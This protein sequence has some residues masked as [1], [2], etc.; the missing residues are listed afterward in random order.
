MFLYI[1]KK[2]KIANKKKTKRAQKM[3]RKQS[4]TEYD[5][6][7]TSSNSSASPSVPKQAR[8]DELPTTEPAPTTTTTMTTNTTVAAD[9]EI[10]EYVLLTKE[11]KAPT[12]ATPD[13]AGFDLYSPR[14]YEIF[15]RGYVE[16]EGDQPSTGTAFIPLDLSIQVPAG[17]YGRIA[18]RSGM[19]A[20]FQMDVLAGTIDRDFLGNVTVGL[21]NHGQTK[22]VIYPGDR[23]A[24][25]IPE[26]I[27]YP[28][29]VER[30]TPFTATKRGTNG[31]GSTGV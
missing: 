4:F 16:T 24:Q 18:P 23:I 19:A 31:F 5:D 14:A 13:A 3:N 6:D 10:L 27:S 1:L 11:A 17:C 25:L 2:K 20:K 28:K 30:K 21:I 9:E 8:H 15:P 22:Y 7:D 26:R 29:L 12:K